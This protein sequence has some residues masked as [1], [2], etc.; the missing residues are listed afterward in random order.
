MSIP[1]SRRTRKGAAKKNTRGAHASRNAGFPLFYWARRI[2]A[3]SP[4]HECMPSA[5]FDDKKN[6]DFLGGSF[7]AGGARVGGR[8]GWERV[9]TPRRGRRGYFA[10]RAVGG[11]LWIWPW[12]GCWSRVAPIRPRQARPSRVA[13][14]VGDARFHLGT[15]LL[16][17]YVAV[18][19][20]KYPRR[21]RRGTSKR[22]QRRTRPRQARP[23]RVAEGAGDAGFH[24]G[25]VPPGRYAA[26]RRAKYP[27]RPRRGTS[28]QGL[29]QGP[30]ATS[31]ALPCGRGRRGRAISRRNSSAGSIRGASARDVQA[32][33]AQGPAA[34][35]A[36]L[37]CGRGCR[38]RG[39]SLRNSS[40]GAIRS[41]SAREV[42]APPSARDVQAGP[43]Q[44]PAA[45]SAALPCGRGCRGCGIS[46]RNSSAGSI[47]GASAR[48]GPA[49]PPA[50]DVQAG[51]AQGPAATSAALPCGRGCRG[52]GISRRNSSAG[53]IRGASA[54]EGPAPPPARDVQAGP[55]QGPAATSAALPC[56]RGCR[57]RAISP[58]NS[59]E[60]KSRITKPTAGA[61]PDYVAHK[62]RGKSGR[63]GGGRLESVV[64]PTSPAARPQRGTLWGGSLR[65]LGRARE[66]RA[67]A[68]V[69]A[70]PLCVTPGPLCVT[71]GPLCTRAN[72]RG[73]SVRTSCAE[74]GADTSHAGGAFMCGSYR[75]TKPKRLGNASVWC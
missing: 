28:K 4:T 21:P 62:K 19:R 61:W 55:A 25:T 59:S 6:S 18:R 16:G 11:R 1:H 14:G 12:V 40:A 34:T 24:V 38:G 68:H 46:R 72:Q 35:S 52:C 39:I 69:G 9:D 27:R 32:D 54:R 48:E 74:G 66:T 50:R 58:R 20:A 64:G 31:A 5:S 37:P 26:R 63:E 17:R 49:P 29:A 23:S 71:S 53:S 13:E 7:A 44:G 10:R 60:V 67:P 73:R 45:T 3:R 41:A 30:A 15:I 8:M 22:A 36:A 57:G 2:S 70:I 43:A 47:R 33:P 56:G 65:G 51:P 42:P 75:N